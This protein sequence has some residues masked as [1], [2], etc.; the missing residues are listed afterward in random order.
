[1]TLP[2][3]NSACS[4]FIAKLTLSACTTVETTTPLALT[5]AL[6]CFITIF[7][8]MF[9]YVQD[10]KPF[11]HSVSSLKLGFVSSHQIFANT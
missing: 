1:M 6:N 8:A 7:I 4:I 3:P 11:T 2:T 9:K 5:V 10:E